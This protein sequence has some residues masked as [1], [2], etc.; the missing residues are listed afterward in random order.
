MTRLIALLVLLTATA[1]LAEPA[2]VIDGDRLELAGE[3]I[4][5]WGIDA[6]EGSQVCQRNGHPWRR[7]GDDGAAAPRGVAERPGTR[8][9][10]G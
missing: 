1:A 6:P 3:R 9:H 4:R 10:R 5:L 7:C 2:R 8:V